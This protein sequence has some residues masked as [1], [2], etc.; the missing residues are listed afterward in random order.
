[1]TAVIDSGVENMISEM[2]SLAG[3]YDASFFRGIADASLTSAREVVP[4][5]IELIHPS[6][7]V[8]VGCGTG[9]WLSAF[10]EAGVKEIAG[11]DGDYV[12]RMQ[13]CIPSNRF[14]AQDLSRGMK[15]KE[16][17]D[18]AISLE[19]GEH[20]SGEVAGQFVKGLTTLAP[21]VV[22]S[23]AVPGQGGVAHINEQWPAYWAARF[24]E[25]GFEAVDILRPLLWD[26]QNIVWYY[27]QNMLLYVKR[28][29][30]GNYA[31]ISRKHE[32][33]DR[34]VMP[35]VHPEMYAGLLYTTRPENVR[36]KTA[37][38]NFASTLIAAARRRRSS[39]TGRVNS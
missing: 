33:T 10:V 38:K 25:N 17:F 23:A 39:K 37:L 1:V 24:A 15:L 29:L 26:N 2:I 31:A 7:V 21:V 34:R 18:L 11:V 28:D 8:D 19:V 30:I 9:G 4:V 22:F 3:P 20:L 35:I 13:L 32:R 6:S 16:K 5:L 36:F 12:D 14:F 27:K